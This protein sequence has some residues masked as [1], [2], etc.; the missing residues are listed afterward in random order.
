MR[1]VRLDDEG[2][3]L[4]AMFKGVIRARQRFGAQSV[5]VVPTIDARRIASVCRVKI[6]A[7]VDEAR[8]AYGQRDMQAAPADRPLAPARQRAA[9]LDPA[10]VLA[11]FEELLFATPSDTPS[12][13]AA[14]DGEAAAKSRVAVG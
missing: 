12:E 13:P 8:Q 3:I 5:E 11:A 1:W 9:R 14:A 2:E 6:P 4:L 10:S 7:I